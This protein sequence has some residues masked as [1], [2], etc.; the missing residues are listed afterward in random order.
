MSAKA[1]KKNIPLLGCHFPLSEDIFPDE[2]AQVFVHSTMGH[3]PEGKI[4]HQ[5]SLYPDVDKSRGFRVIHTGYVT[6]PWISASMRDTAGESDKLKLLKQ[7]RDSLL[8]VE[9]SLKIGEIV[10]ARLLLIHLPSTVRNLE[11]FKKSTETLG[12]L[13][14]DIKGLDYVFEVV[15]NGPG[16]GDIFPSTLVE[17]LKAFKE[18]F[19]V[20]LGKESDMKRSTAPKVL[21]YSFCIDTAHVWAQGVSLTTKD[22]VKKL[23]EELS[24]NELHVSLFHLNGNSIELGEHRDRHEICMSKDDLMWRKDSSG[25]SEI[26]DWSLSLNVPLILERDLDVALREREILEKFYEES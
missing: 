11:E 18:V 25:L 4:E 24:S 1:T 5:R 7:T 2:I 23:R 26:L 14:K 10:G 22:D 15:S 16:P 8:D 12:K 3:V 13:I 6:Y 21:R 20:Y 19:D 17:R 9:R